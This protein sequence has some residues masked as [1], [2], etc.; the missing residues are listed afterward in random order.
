M[1]ALRQMLYKNSSDTVI[2]LF[3]V[4]VLVWLLVLMAVGKARLF[5]EKRRRACARALTDAAVAVS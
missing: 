1:E 5:Q 2:Y 4:L 3:I